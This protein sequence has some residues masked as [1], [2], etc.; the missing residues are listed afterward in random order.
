MVIRDQRQEE[1]SRTMCPVTPLREA[2]TA[3]LII[4]GDARHIPLTDNSIQ[5]VVTS[6]PYW[7]L[8]DYG[9]VGGIGL[10]ASIDDHIANLVS[11]F[12]EVRRVLHPSGTV[13]INCG[14]LYTS[15]DRATYRSGASENKGHDVQNDMPRPRTPNGLKP[16][17]LVGLPWMLAFAL[18]AD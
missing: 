11:V 12:R 9:L 6:P 8:R 15:G 3:G 4:R 18:R 13:W 17:D 2:R 14:D 10:E 7:G 16:K 5:C 1:L